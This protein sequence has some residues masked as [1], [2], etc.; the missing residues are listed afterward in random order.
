L[1]ITQVI[2]DAIEGIVVEDSDDMKEVQEEL[3]EEVNDLMPK[4]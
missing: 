1:A 4:G 3:M 2:Y